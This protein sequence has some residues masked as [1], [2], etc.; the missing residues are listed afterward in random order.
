VAGGGSSVPLQHT[1]EIVLRP[2]S[3]LLFKSGRCATRDPE[4][5]IVAL[6]GTL[7][8][9]F[10]RVMRGPILDTINTLPPE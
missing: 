1:P 10:V 3:A 5:V 6:R 9:L 8:L 2:H 4:K 7:Y